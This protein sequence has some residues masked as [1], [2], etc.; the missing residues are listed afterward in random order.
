MASHFR[1]RV[2]VNKMCHVAKTRTLHVGTPLTCSG[3]LLYAQTNG[4]LSPHGMAIGEAFASEQTIGLQR[5]AL[6][7][8]E[9]INTSL[10]IL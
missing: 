7:G 6:G 5:E 1:V 4:P 8:G 3:R 2:W 9:L 10:L